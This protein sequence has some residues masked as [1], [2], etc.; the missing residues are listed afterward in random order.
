MRCARESR[1]L[2]TDPTAPSKTLRTQLQTH[3]D[4]RLIDRGQPHWNRPRT[5][6]RV[7]HSSGEAREIRPPQGWRRVGSCMAGGTMITPLLVRHP[8]PFRTESLFGY[9]LRLSEENGY[10][11]PWSLFLLAQIRQHEARSTGMKAAKVAQ[12]CNRSRTELQSISY[13]WPGDHPRSCRLLGHLLIPWEL[14]VTGPKLCPECVAEKGFIEAHF[15]LALMTG[16]PVHRRSLLSRC[17]G[18]MKPLRWFRPGLLEC[19]CGASLRSAD[20]PAISGAEADL[21]DIMRRETLGLAA[22]G[23]YASGLPG[24]HL[25]VMNLQP[26]LSLVGTL[27]RRRMVVDNDSDRRNS[28]R[29]VFAA[30]RVLAD[31]PNNFL[32]LLRE[33]TEGM[34]ANSDSSNGVARGKLGGIYRSLLNLR[35]IM[36]TEQ[37]DFLRIAFLDFVRNDWRPDFIDQKLMKRLR[38]GQSER[39]ISRA[40]FARRYGIDTRAAARFVEDQ[41]VP[42]RTFR[43]GKS[44]RKL[45]D[46]A[47]ATL[48]PTVPG[49]IYRLRQAAA[50]VGISSE[51]LKYLKASGDFEV[52]HLLRTKP[53]FH[54]LDIEAFIQR[55]NSLA[56]PVNPADLSSSKY[57]RFAIVARGWYGS[58]EAK[59]HVVRAVLSRK[60]PVVGDVDGTVA[61]LL[62][63]YEGFQRLAH[64]E[65][66]RA[67]GD[68]RTIAEAARQLD[69]NTRSVRRLVELEWLTASR[70]S[71][72]LRVTE[73]SIAEFKKRYV[74]L[75]S[76]ARTTNSASWAL[77]NICKRCNVPLLVA[78]Q[79]SKKSSQAFIRAGQRQ[80]LL[81]LR[82]GLSLKSLSPAPGGR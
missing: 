82:S 16:C 50:M 27:G 44:E 28:Q 38:T 2:W 43:W 69:C 33:I 76:I 67:H 19:R 74:S 26:L 5:C 15:D 34:S 11:T 80:E 77:Q 48:S 54:E 79:P 78:S 10:T 63:S 25:E 18:C 65:R 9:I 42:S 75:L 35:R 20:L 61:G 3:S 47:A 32:R 62:V 46:S 6:G 14:V 51:L 58:V 41:G 21:L 53:G 30:A 55:L 70:A 17:P 59:A 52:N 37:A 36:P 12:V 49:K 23:G 56:P 8:A 73:E 39:F 57:V 66:A 81:G 29:I 45:I 71:K 64:D 60:L 22:G 68:T 7:R 13:R 40:A 4:G 72:A 1:V 24:S 31:W